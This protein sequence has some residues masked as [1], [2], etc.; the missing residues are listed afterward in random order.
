M[1]L[2]YEPW[3]DPSSTEKPPGAIYTRPSTQDPWTLSQVIDGFPT[4]TNG[5]DFLINKVLPGSNSPWGLW[6]LNTGNNTYSE[7][8]T[9][10]EINSGFT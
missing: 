7:I 5:G 4:P 2:A 10:F 1:L 3:A 8:T 9:K 6:E